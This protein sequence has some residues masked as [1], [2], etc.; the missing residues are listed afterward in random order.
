VLKIT[1]LPRHGRSVTIT[2]EGAVYGPWVEEVRQACAVVDVSPNLIRL[3]LSAVTFV[4]GAG[5]RLLQSLISQG[6]QLAACSGFVGAV[7]GHERS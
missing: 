3:D 5:V 4:D 7:L 1:R 2:L 6:V